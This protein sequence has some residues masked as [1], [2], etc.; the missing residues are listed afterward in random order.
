MHTLSLRIYR[1]V[2]GFLAIILTFLVFPATAYSTDHDHHFVEVSR[3]GYPCTGYEIVLRCDICGEE[4]TDYIDPTAAHI[5]EVTSKEG[6]SCQGWYVDYKCS[7][8]G[9]TDYEW[10]EPTTDHNYIE[11]DRQNPTYWEGG[12]VE[13]TCS[14]CQDVTWT[15]LDKLSIPNSGVLKVVLSWAEPMD[16]DS[17]LVGMDDAKIFQVDFMTY[18]YNGTSMAAFLDNDNLYGNDPPETITLYPTTNSG[19]VSYYV[20]DFGA[21]DDKEAMGLSESNATVR[22]YLDDV[23]VKSYEVPNIVGSY[24]HVFDYNLATK[25]I[26][27]V[28]S[29]SVADNLTR[30][31]L[32]DGEKTIRVYEIV[33]T[34]GVRRALEGV[35]IT[36]ESSDESSRN[37]RKR[38]N[39]NIVE[40]KTDA[41]GSARCRLDSERTAHF[42][43]DGYSATNRTYNQ[44]LNN[45]T[46]ILAKPSTNPT[47]TDVWVDDYSILHKNYSISFF[48]PR[49]AEFTADINWGGYSA[50]EVFL[51][52]GEHRVG[53]PIDA[54]TGQYRN[55]FLLK[56]CGFNEFED[57]TLRLVSS[58]GTTTI[59]ELNTKSYPVALNFALKDGK[60]SLNKPEFLKNQELKTDSTLFKN[61]PITFVDDGQGIIKG[62]IG[63]NLAYGKF[64]KTTTYS[65]EGISIETEREKAGAV[66]E[67]MRE[68]YNNG[69]PDTSYLNSKLEKLC[70]NGISIPALSSTVGIEGS[71]F[72]GGYFEFAY[73]PNL[74]DKNLRYI[75]GGIIIEPK[76]SANVSWMF[77]PAEYVTVKLSAE[78]KA[79]L[80]LLI[81]S[82]FDESENMLSGTIDIKI[83]ASIAG[84]VGV[85]G[86]FS[87]EIEAKG[88]LSPTITISDTLDFNTTSVRATLQAGVYVDFIGT[89]LQLDSWELADVQLYPSYEPIGGGGG[90]GG[91]FS[92]EPYL[93]IYDAGSYKPTDLSY[94]S[95][96]SVFYGKSSR[97]KAGRR[98][99]DYQSN[100]TIKTNVLRDADP[101]LVQF[102]NG[103]LLMVWLDAKNE[104]RNTIQ[105]YYSIH[106]ENGWSEPSLVSDDNSIDYKPCLI[107]INDIAYLAWM[108]ADCLFDD[109]DSLTEMADHFGISVA[110]FDPETG[111]K[112]HYFDVPGPDMLP[113]VCGNEEG[114]Y[115][116]WVNNSNNDWF[117]SGNTNSI[118]YSKQLSGEWTS[119]TVLY[120]NLNRISSIAASADGDELHV[121]Y[122]EDADGSND[123][124][125]DIRLFEDGSLISS[126][127]HKASSPQYWNGSL[128]WHEDAMDPNDE[129]ICAPHLIETGKGPIINFSGEKAQLLRVSNDSG[130]SLA[131]SYYDSKERA[132]LEPYPIIS[133]SDLI[134]GYSCVVNKAGSLEIIYT[135]RDTQNSNSIM[136]LSGETLLKYATISPF[137]RFEI[138]GI[139]FDHSEL[140]PGNTLYLEIEGY[141][142]GVITSSSDTVVLTDDSGNP[143]A[144]SPIAGKT[145]PGEMFATEMLLPVDEAMLGKTYSVEIVSNNLPAPATIGNN[146]V[147]FDYEDLAVENIIWAE[148]AYGQLI[149]SA[150]VSNYGYSDRNDITVVLES[151]NESDYLAKSVIRV[152]PTMETE[153]V[154]FNINSKVVD[155]IFS[156]HI[157]DSG[158]LITGNDIDHVY[159]THTDTRWARLKTFDEQGLVL[160]L[161][162]NPTGLCLV[163]VYDAEGRFCNISSRRVE[164]DC[165]EITLGLKPLLSIANPVIK[166][167]IIDADSF[168]PL[169]ESIT[170]HCR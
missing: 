38:A 126:D 95:G 64:K 147:T 98:T 86:V 69:I 36:F 71:V 40:Y 135:L 142:T 58:E 116:V 35:S 29:A 77:P 43:L 165:G 169:R 96:E 82:N 30:L 144:F 42:T 79:K 153:D 97:F 53:L 6:A 49:S 87:A 8:C 56:D 21:G 104:D 46:V 111:F 67:T 33:G 16:L 168:K 5:F 74:S 44:L 170:I 85:D 150:R 27:S 11:T 50:G 133:E 140:V 105:L 34:T 113:K 115:L 160:D 129:G 90:G 161:Q 31:E 81:S 41:T 3:V 117:G 48:Y 17:I 76:V 122:C 138:E 107:I 136:N 119:P 112:S 103:T 93:K 37:S 45:S 10:I 123:T 91:A 100:Y 164:N 159:I 155:G 63:F 125:S 39:P 156:V 75:D 166:V 60:I 148:D 7:V 78:A 72:V 163:A 151:E 19:I 55:V 99:A 51:S 52:Q 145:H 143:V 1:I 70:S 84:G 118:F 59:V 120:N 102:N 106:D 167:L 130:Y 12:F 14:I 137:K 54:K 149:V 22:V 62:I 141:N 114:I 66:F 61:L 146:R 110:V 124:Q 83:E 15:E 158:D 152:L 154:T 162:G 20:H 24:W 25:Q 134:S 4:D 18:E 121:A 127:D 2:S 131:L 80:K 26:T 92:I 57:L 89:S 9:E 73:S 28:N 94:L 139:Y 101:Q 65:D 88:K 109:E 23:L 68:L 128:Y 13:Y 32:F 157:L 132:W 47:A 108:N